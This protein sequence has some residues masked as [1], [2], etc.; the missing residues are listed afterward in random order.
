[1][2]SDQANPRG[3]GERAKQNQFQ[4]DA[5]IRRRRKAFVRFDQTDPA[6][7]S[8]LALNAELKRDSA[9][10]SAPLFLPGPSTKYQELKELAEKTQ[11]DLAQEES[12][13]LTADLFSS[14]KVQPALPLLQHL[15]FLASP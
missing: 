3:S 2:K 9:Q 10:C 11:A 6:E 4:P 15:A 8:R 1:M 5:W 14:P 13:V 7:E 12:F